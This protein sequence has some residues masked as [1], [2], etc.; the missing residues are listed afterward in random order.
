MTYSKENQPTK[1]ASATSKKY[2]SSE[3][4]SDVCQVSQMY[5]NLTRTIL[6]LETGQGGEY[7]AES[8]HHYE[9]AGHNGDNLCSLRVVRVLEQVPQLTLGRGAE[10]CS[11][12]LFFLLL[13]YE[14]KTSYTLAPISH[15]LQAFQQPYFDNP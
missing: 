9:Q 11:K 14:F 12:I 3:T 13:K 1:T 2:S 15:H 6:L 4:N 7:Q 5:Q 10:P 8:G